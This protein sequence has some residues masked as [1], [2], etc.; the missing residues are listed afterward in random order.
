MLG[1]DTAEIAALQATVLVSEGV[2]DAK[3]RLDT[4]AGTSNLE[5]L[6]ELHAE[7]AGRQAMERFADEIFGV[8]A[9]IRDPRIL[10]RVGRTA[11]VLGRTSPLRGMGGLEK[12]GRFVVGGRV[13][14]RIWSWTK[15]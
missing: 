13:R 1:L 2:G 6:R 14:R 7:P 5:L 4:L 9:G 8:A 3:Q 11:A 15:G 10:G 12:L